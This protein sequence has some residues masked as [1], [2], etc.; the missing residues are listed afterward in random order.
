MS[1]RSKFDRIP[2][3]EVQEPKPWHLPYWVEPPH[4]VQ[5]EEDVLVEE[6]EIEVEPLTAEQLEQIRQ[7]AYNEGLEQGLVE[8]RQKGE[9]LGYEAGHKE[10]V[11]EGHKEGLEKGLAEGKE[12]GETTALQEGKARTDQKVVELN[13]VL[14]ELYQP[15]KQEKEQ[16]DTL[17]PE[18]VLKLVEQI[19]EAELGSG[20]D[21][22]V[23]FVKQALLDLPTGAENIQIY[24]NALDLPYVE[25][26]IE[27]DPN[28]NEQWSIHEDTSIQAGGCRIGSHE[29]IV[30]FT[31]E[32]RWQKLLNQFVENYQ[33]G[34]LKADSLESPTD[35]RLSDQETAENNEPPST[36]STDDPLTVQENVNKGEEFEEG[37]EGKQNEEPQANTETNEHSSAEAQVNGA[38]ELAEQVEGQSAEQPLKQPVEQ[39]AEQSSESETAVHSNST[40]PHQDGDHSEMGQSSDIEESAEQDQKPN[41]DSD[42]SPD[43]PE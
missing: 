13:S 15:I 1:K 2:A 24:L 20:S 41:V 38:Q 32:K 22:A 28:W 6:E 9:K 43:L 4:L 26:A 8:G 35:N 7:E 10:G 19:V 39:P 14:N 18:L 21:H 33:L 27:Q 40:P 3:E 31:R 12:Q 5:Q 11:E 34:E 25:A 37:E 42:Q 23:R 17:L 36:A 29:S 16:L 30:D